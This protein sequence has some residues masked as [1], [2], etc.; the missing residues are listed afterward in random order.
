MMNEF[1]IGTSEMDLTNIEELDVPLEIPKSEYY[2]YARTVNKGNG[3]KRGVGFAMAGW[4][5]PLLTVEQRDQLK[6]FCPDASGEVVIRTK[7]N[8]DTWGTFHSTMIW[9]ENEPRWYG[10]K[11]NYLIQFR[12]LVLIPEGS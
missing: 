8:D 2:P 3:G 9:V 5:F 12:N 4:T 6:L 11:Q 7:L 10:V 1:M